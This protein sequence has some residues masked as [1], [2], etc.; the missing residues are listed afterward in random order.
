MFSVH[1]V[2]KHHTSGQKVAA[3]RQ[4][5]SGWTWNDGLAEITGVFLSDD[6]GESWKRISLQPAASPYAWQAFQAEVDL[7]PGM[8]E[9]WFGALDALGRAQPSS[10]D[11]SWNPKG[12][13]WNAVE[14][15]S[16]NVQ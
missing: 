8:T 13:E 3:G 16:L 2:G 9:L 6:F 14:R 5:I 7:K 12:Y 1:I 4:R 10:G 11:L 15:I